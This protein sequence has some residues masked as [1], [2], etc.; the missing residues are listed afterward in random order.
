MLRRPLGDD[1]PVITHYFTDRTDQK[2]QL[3]EILDTPRGEHVPVLAW[4]GVAGAG[5]SS[6]VRKLR[7]LL[8]TEHPDVPHALW[9]FN[10]G[11]DREKVLTG[12]RNE[13]VLWSRALRGKD[14]AFPRF[15]VAQ[16]VLSEKM[17]EATRQAT[18]ES[19]GRVV[20][21]VVSAL[22]TSVWSLLV[23]LLAAP[24]LDRLIK[25]VPRLRDWLERR[26][27]EGRERERLRPMEPQEVSEQLVWAFAT[28]LAELLT[29][30]GLRERFA[31]RAVVFLDAYERLFAGMEGGDAAQAQ[32]RDAWVQKELVPDLWAAGVQVIIAGRDRLRWEA[33]GFDSADLE[34]HL[35]G[36]I[37]NEDADAYLVQL[38]I[39]DSK[40]R[41]AILDASRE[42]AEGV[43]AFHYGLCIDIWRENEGRIEPE[44]FQELASA[45]DKDRKLA[46]RFLESLPA[47][48][49]WQS[50][51]RGLSLPR[52]FDRESIGA[53]RRGLELPLAP[54]EAW[55]RLCGFSFVEEAEG[56][57]GRY[58]MHSVMRGVLRE[59]IEAKE[60]ELALALGALEECHT[61]RAVEPGDAHAAEAWY[62]RF[63]RDPR[64]AAEAWSS[65]VER[66]VEGPETV[67]VARAMLTWWDGIDL[68]GEAPDDEAR[69]YCL[70]LLANRLWD[71]PQRDM[72]GP[73]QRAIECYEAAL[74]IYTE[75]AAP[76]Q[77]ATIQI[78]LGN[79]YQK[80]PTG[81]RGE[82]LRLAIECYEAALTVYTEEAAP[83]DW[84]MTQNNLGNAYDD[85]PTG[86]RGE[87]LRR[88]IE[89]Y[90]AA[91]R[92]WT[93]EEEAREWAMTQN[94][95]GNAYHR[96]PTGDRG[97]N[98]C[99]AIKCYKAALRVRTKEAAP[100]GWAMTQN[101]LGNAYGD[102][103]TGDR[104]EN[105]R[106]AV[107]CYEAA[108]RVYTEEAAPQQWAGIQNNLG[109]AYGDLPTGDR[110]EN[111]RRAIECYEAALR[112]YTEEAA[113]H[114]WAGTQ[115]NLGNAYANLP[116]GDRGENLH[117]AIERYEAALRVYT[118]EAAPYQ[119]ATT[120]NNLGTAYS[121]LP[122]GDRGENL[123]LAIERYE[124]AL[125]I[126]TEEAA[127]HDWAMTQNNLGIA[128][129]NL[130]TG[131]RGE[132]LHR[133]I[134]H[135]EAALRVRTEEE[136]PHE[137][138]TTQNNLGTAYSDLPTSDRGENLRRAIEYYEA[139]LRVYTEEADPEGHARLCN[140][141]AWVLA[142]DMEPSR[143]S[144]ALPLAEKAVSLAPESATLDT[145]AH[146]YYRLERWSE[147]LE[148]WD[149]A[150]A[151][152]PSYVD[153]YN[154]YE[155]LELREMVE[156]ARRRASEA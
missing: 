73:L 148:A 60:R 113:P 62:M 79:A 41:D 128:Y 105:L 32:Y 136:A 70:V 154:A 28:D 89:H 122:T 117:R 30:Y 50:L 36:G 96:L 91:L 146:C 83:H 75:E 145:L 129:A 2:E 132:N 109:N 35:L 64:S 29:K 74:R 6:L 11:F 99:L 52:W 31:R 141:L 153:D 103:P 17:G 45:G 54:G 27:R 101:N 37:S 123:R 116:T 100:R 104:G 40:L 124:A 46:R 59:E 127:P 80:L 125:R 16:S 114:Q 137:W 119:W 88:A 9:D 107:E 33:T 131:D 43:H 4:Y 51:V 118:E 156:E 94:N 86:D 1:A 21:S 151:L 120:Q 90:E 55:R 143:P 42:S 20:A 65:E 81:D 44:R 84:A 15:D 66:L 12:L 111:P 3:R 14:F 18:M 58:R 121:D 108:R 76:Q 152:D 72:R 115:N 67:A 53:V 149:R 48:G 134:E 150:L 139:A 147:A 98:L 23:S 95:L 68:E 78:A 142:H 69:A 97:E 106:L 13:L 26:S 77:W 49:D 39:D 56:V 126:Y 24:V 61:G 7:E 25:N 71:V 138:A 92:V 47:E 133:A 110:G 22:A 34:Q 10:S 87:N 57:P 5:K 38:G 63:S 8:R 130:P 144:E 112:V 93:E 19:V 140:N 135:Y 102:L 155:G 85:L 82:N